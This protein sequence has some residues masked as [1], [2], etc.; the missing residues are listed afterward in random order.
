VVALTAA[1]SAAQRVRG[2]DLE[3]STGAARE[4]PGAALEAADLEGSAAGA[5]LVQAPDGERPAGRDVTWPQGVRLGGAS[6]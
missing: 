6:W 4:L 5:G 2:A 3:G 1:E